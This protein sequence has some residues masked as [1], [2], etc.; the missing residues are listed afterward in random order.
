MVN[1][2]FVVWYDKELKEIMCVEK[3]HFTSSL[4]IQLI[5]ENIQVYEMNCEFRK[6]ATNIFLENFEKLRPNVQFGNV[7]NSSFLIH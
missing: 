6:D 7:S 2:L 5:K 3:Q 4:S 1:N